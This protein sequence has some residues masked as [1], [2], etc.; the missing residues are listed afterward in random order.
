MRRLLREKT[1]VL[2]A[3]VSKEALANRIYH[4]LVEIMEEYH[5]DIYEVS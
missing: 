3:C 4:Q 2:E 5:V 1:D